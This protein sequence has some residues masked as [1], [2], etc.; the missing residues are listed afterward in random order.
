MKQREQKRKEAIARLEQ[1]VNIAVRY[2]GAR[3]R[4]VEDLDAVQ[5]RRRAEAVRLKELR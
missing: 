1:S 5:V 2:S 4:T 3:P